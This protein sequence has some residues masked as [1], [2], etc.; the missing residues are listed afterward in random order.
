[1]IL[2]MPSMHSGK[3]L[4]GEDDFLGPRQLA[5]GHGPIGPHSPLRIYARLPHALVRILTGIRGHLT[6]PQ[7]P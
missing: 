2:A 5:M 7:R 4:K 1:M 6:L 3:S